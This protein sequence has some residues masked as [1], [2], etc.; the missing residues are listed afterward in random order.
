M[1][2]IRGWKRAKAVGLSIGFINGALLI[3]CSIYRKI[4]TF[5]RNVKNM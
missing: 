1:L 2:I 3:S 5:L 4:V